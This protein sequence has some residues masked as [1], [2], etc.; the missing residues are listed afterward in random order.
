MLENRQKSTVCAQ[1]EFSRIYRYKVDTMSF[2]ACN[3]QFRNFIISIAIDD[4]WFHILF[5]SGASG[6]MMQFVA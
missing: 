6:T 1:S 4:N 2:V 3:A 5:T